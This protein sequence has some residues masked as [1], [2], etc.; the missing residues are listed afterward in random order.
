[1]IK[2]NVVAF[3]PRKTV[4]PVIVELPNNSLPSVVID[5]IGEVY[6][7]AQTQGIDTESID[8]KY[9]AATIMTVLQGMLH[10]R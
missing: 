1:M 9:E 6:A 10:K 3:Q 2:S 4:D 5:F 7:W 8:F